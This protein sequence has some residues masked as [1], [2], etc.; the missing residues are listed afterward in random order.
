[1][2]VY[3]NSDNYFKSRKYC[4][5]NLSDGFTLLETLTVILMIGILSAIAV[6]SWLGFVQTQSLNAGQSQVYSAMRQAQRQAKKEKLTFQASFREQNGIVQW[7]VHRDTV[8]PSDAN[9]NNLNSNIC[10]D[11][12]TTLQLSNGVRRIKFDYTGN[13]KQPPLGRI[14]LS[15]LSTTCGGKVKRCVIVSTILG[16]MRTA[17]EQ[18]KMK[19]N[20]YCY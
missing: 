6:P 17:K 8:N 4:H 11:P 7:A 12:E 13:V 5:A 16:A 9:W 1:M 3:K 2:K 20:K 15:T 14:T 18:S 10:L 19:D